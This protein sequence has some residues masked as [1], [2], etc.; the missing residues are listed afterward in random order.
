MFAAVFS[1]FHQKKAAIYARIRTLES[2]DKKSTDRT[3]AYFEA[4]YDAID[5]PRTV[6]EAFLGTCLKP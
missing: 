6:R 2:P 3:L 5:D 4:F 1:V